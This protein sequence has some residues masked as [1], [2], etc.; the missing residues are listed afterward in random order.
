M[1]T[2]LFL[3]RNHPGYT[4]VHYQGQEAE[5]QDTL[6]T[7]ARWDTWSI[8]NT[9]ISEEDIQKLADDFRGLP[10]RNA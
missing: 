10:E 4:M 8:E 6:S 1:P 3:Q 5:R 7:P 2:Q 9:G